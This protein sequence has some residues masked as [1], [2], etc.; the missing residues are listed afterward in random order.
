[1]I[2]VARFQ[3]TVGSPGRNGRFD[4]VAR[5]LTAILSAESE[6]KQVLRLEERYCQ[7]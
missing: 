3:H 7:A 4:Q 2:S 5:V 1:M 6:L